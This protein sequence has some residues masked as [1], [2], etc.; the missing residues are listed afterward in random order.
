MPSSYL[1][2]ADGHVLATHLGFKTADAPD[3]ERAIREALAAAS[4]T[5]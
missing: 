2:D 1:L 4:V 5:Q 3:Y